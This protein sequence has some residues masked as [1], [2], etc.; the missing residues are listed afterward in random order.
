MK[1]PEQNQTFSIS[2]SRTSAYNIIVFRVPWAWGKG[3]VSL[4]SLQSL[5][6]ILGSISSRWKSRPGRI[7]TITADFVKTTSVL[8]IASG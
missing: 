5:Q 6:N 7:R 8:L 4:Q 2:V 3:L 1:P